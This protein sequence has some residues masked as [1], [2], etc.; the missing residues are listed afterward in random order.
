MK[1]WSYSTP[2]AM[3]ACGRKPTP[4]TLPWPGLRYRFLAAALERDLLL[5]FFPEGD[6]HRPSLWSGFHRSRDLAICLELLGLF[7][8]AL[9]VYRETDAALRGDAL[10]A[11]GRLGPLLDQPQAPPPWQML[12]GAYRAHA[13][14]LAGLTDEAVALAR[15]LVPMDI[16][17]WTHVFECLLRAGRLDALDLRSFLYRPPH[18]DGHR[19]ADLARERMRA[20]YLRVTGPSDGLGATYETLIEDYDRGGLPYERTLTRL[21]YARWLLAVGRIEEAQAVNAIA[22]AL[23]ERHSMAIVEADAWTVE[24]ELVRRNGADGF[25]ETASAA[26]LRQATGYHG[27]DR[28]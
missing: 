21:G 25:V 12:W 3:A 19:W 20:D 27:P 24:A 6:W 16:Y 1:R 11:L 13:L 17:E 10:L 26:R 7:E 18:A 9:L 5:R 15:S 8:E 22:R 28:P 2:T 14:C 4:P 23:A